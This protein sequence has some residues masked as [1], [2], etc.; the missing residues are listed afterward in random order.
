[1]DLESFYYVGLSKTRDHNMPNCFI[2][3][4]EL[5]IW[6]HAFIKNMPRL[7]HK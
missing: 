3:D 2:Y 5:Y 6:I 7:E 4:W 1:M